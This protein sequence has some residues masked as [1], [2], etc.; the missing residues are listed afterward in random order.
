MIQEY[1]RPVGHA[2]LIREPVDGLVGRIRET[3]PS[4]TNEPLAA[5]QLT[6][7]PTNEASWNDLQAIF[8][9]SD[10]PGHCYCQGYKTFDKDWKSVSDEQ[11]REKL[12]QR[13]TVTTLVPPALRVSSPT[14]GRRLSAGWPQ[15]HARHIRAC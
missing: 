14:W 7:L 12:R 4:P 1:A 5:D 11:R 6:I 8:G 13:P 3:S 10:Y 15:N 9:T 2:D